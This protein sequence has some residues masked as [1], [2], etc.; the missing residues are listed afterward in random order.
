MLKRQPILPKG[1][2]LEPVGLAVLMS[3]YE[4]LPVVK[5]THARTRHSSLG[6]NKHNL[7]ACRTLVGLWIGAK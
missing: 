4:S 7:I 6:L 3:M 5:D 1:V 2:N